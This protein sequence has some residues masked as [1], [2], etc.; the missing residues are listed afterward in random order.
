MN[1]MTRI[2]SAISFIPAIDRELWVEIGMAVKSE[3]GEAGRD[4]WDSWSRQ[5]E[6][7]RPESAKAVWRSIK[8]SGRITVASLYHHAKAHGWRDDGTLQPLSAR[9]IAERRQAS[10]ERAAAADKEAEKEHAMA[11][12]RAA[13]LLAAC[14]LANHPYLASKGFPDARALVDADGAMLVPMRD[15][16]SGKLLGVQKIA[17]IDNEWT[18]KML[19]GM[20]AK[21]AICRIGNAR[22]AELWFVEGYA[23]GLSVDAA[24]KLLRLS[25]AVVVCFSAGNLIYVAGKF[26]GRHYVFADND[27]S[28]TGERSAWKTGLPYAMAPTTG[29]DAND[30]HMAAGV[31]AVAKKIMEARSR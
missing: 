4:L 8:S 10:I 12:A 11:A 18:K 22:S 28:L 21:G 3:L 26:T 19:P 23:T 24:L 30:L 31:M 9:Q 1:E 15:C 20:R 17:L 5:A 29:Q 14:E 2:E 7:Y 16:L 6:S 25:A 13:T 27:A